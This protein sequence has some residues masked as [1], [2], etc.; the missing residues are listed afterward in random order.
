M[1]PTPAAERTQKL[2][3]A[4]EEG[5]PVFSSPVESAAP[6]SVSRSLA[7]RLGICLSA[8]C[9]I[10]C[11]LTPVVLI[12]LPSMRL[13]EMHETYHQFMLVI[14]PLLAILA[15]IPGFRLHRDPRVFMWAVPGLVLIALGAI[16]FHERVWL[17]AAA[18]IAGSV[19]LIRSHL[20]NRTLCSCC[21]TGHAANTTGFFRRK[22]RKVDEG[23]R[24][25]RL[26]STPRPTI[27][28]GR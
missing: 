18:S 14:L 19:L 5:A 20:L 6:V 17:E 23:K 2:E 24:T 27:R 13:L 10:H 22:Y 15:F 11:L 12:A 3:L 4:I 25:A 26:L 28:S 21:E 16:V 1:E 8:L 9:V 7:D